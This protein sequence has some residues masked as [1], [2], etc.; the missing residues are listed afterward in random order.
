[1]EFNIRNHEIHSNI[2]QCVDT[3]DYFLDSSITLKL[4]KIVNS[5]IKK[6]IF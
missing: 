3:T 1:M 4:F 6:S 2:R 5:I